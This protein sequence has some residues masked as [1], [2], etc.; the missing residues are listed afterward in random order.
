MTNNAARQAAYRERHLH[1]VEGQGVRINTVVS[2]K[3]KLALERMAKCYGATQRQMLE[4]ALG[5]QKR[6]RWT[7]LRNSTVRRMPTMT[8]ICAWG[9][10]P[11]RMDSMGAN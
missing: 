2:I 1:D 5:A 8:S 7:G 11:L 4:R 3:A 6:P 9:Q 10:I